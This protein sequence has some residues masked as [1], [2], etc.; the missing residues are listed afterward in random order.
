MFKVK[1]K[2]PYCQHQFETNIFRFNATLK[3]SHCHK[4]IYI[5]TRTA[6][7]MILLIFFMMISTQMNNGIKALLPGMP[8]IVYVVVL[9]VLMLGAVF[10]LMFISCKLFGFTS[11]YRIRSDEYYTNVVK[12]AGQ[13]RMEK[14][15]NKRNKKK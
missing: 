14:Q 9:F 6:F 11:I 3:C 12:R 4:K 5:E 10:V 15:A 1:E 2:C 13:R 7:Y 8:D